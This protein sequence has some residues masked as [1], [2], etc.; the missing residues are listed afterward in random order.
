MDADRLS[1]PACGLVI[2]KAA[3]SHR[4]SRAGSQT[5]CPIAALSRLSKDTDVAGVTTLG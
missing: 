3:C 2:C 4:T 1:G 5:A